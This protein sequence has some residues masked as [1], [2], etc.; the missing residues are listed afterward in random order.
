MRLD[1][2]DITRATADEIIKM[3]LGRGGFD[4]WWSQIDA[5]DQDDIRNEIATI[6]WELV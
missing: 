3:L 6:I 4:E 1:E 5:D 2:Q